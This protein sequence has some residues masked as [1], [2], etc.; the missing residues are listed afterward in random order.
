M[1]SGWILLSVALG[2]G[3]GAVLRYLAVQIIETPSGFPLATLV[4]NVLGSFLIGVCFVLI[5]EKGLISELWRPALMAGFLGGLTT[6]SAFSLEAVYLLEDGRWQMAL[7]YVV[8]SLILCILAA[9]GGMQL[10]RSL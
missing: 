5:L 8:M 3:L 6:F 1:I 9:F 2:G 7:G 4:V 10:V